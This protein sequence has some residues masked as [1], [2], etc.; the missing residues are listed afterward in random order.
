MMRRKSLV[1][2]AALSYMSSESFADNQKSTASKLPS[3]FDRPTN[4]HSQVVYNRQQLLPTPFL[5]LNGKPSG[6]SILSKTKTAKLVVPK[7]PTQNLF[8]SESVNDNVSLVTLDS[9]PGR[10]Q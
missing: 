4:V 1:S 6:K 10:Q 7:P 2:L 9:E 5:A 3:V 8:M